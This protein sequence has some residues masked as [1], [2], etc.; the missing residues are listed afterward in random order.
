[1][2][3]PK[4]TISL[5][6]VKHVAA[7]AHLPLTKSQIARY[8]SQLTNI[9]DYVSQIKQLKTSKVKETS[10]LTQSTNR[11][12]ED[13]VTAE[14]MLSQA[15]ALSNAKQTHHGYFVVTAILDQS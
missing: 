9:L 2:V 3:K 1:M 8:Q 15:E 10:Q 12:R 14:T 11:T 4:A 5:D 13:K 6:S 7:L